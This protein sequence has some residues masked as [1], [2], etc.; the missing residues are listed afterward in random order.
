MVLRIASAA[1]GIQRQD[2]SG[3]IQQVERGGE[4]AAH[5]TRRYQAGAGEREVV[6]VVVRL[7]AAAGDGDEAT[8]G[9]DRAVIA[10][11]IR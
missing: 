7:I 2:I 6:V 1:P 9:R 4:I 10:I 5:R 3:G 8:R 11:R